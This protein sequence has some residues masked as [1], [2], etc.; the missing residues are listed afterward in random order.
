[1]RFHSLYYIAHQNDDHHICLD[2]DN[3]ESSTERP[4]Q[5]DEDEDELLKRAIAM[6]LEEDPGIKEDDREDKEEMLAKAIALSLQEP[7]RINDEEEMSEEEMLAI[8]L[9]LSMVEK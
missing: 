1:M 4:A 2:S 7:S 3:H 8:A 9:A 5:V 6:S